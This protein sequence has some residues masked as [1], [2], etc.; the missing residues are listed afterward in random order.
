M[1]A[2]NGLSLELGKYQKH[3][4]IRLKEMQDQGFVKRLWNKDDS[5]WMKGN[6]KS[7]ISTLSM[8]WLNVTNKMINNLP[9]IKEF[10]ETI[11]LEGFTHIVLLGMGG[12]SLTPLVFQK[13][14]LSK[15]SNGQSSA[16]NIEFIVLDS[17]EPEMVRNVENKINIS[18]T[19]FIVASKSGNTAEVMAFYNY[20]FKQ[21]YAVKGERTGDNF[22]AITDEGSPLSELAIRQKF[23]KSFINFTDI[24]GRYSALSYF[25][26]LPAALMGVN[27]K[28]LLE[29]TLIMI[30]ACGS[31]VPA[32]QNPGVILGAA[33][34]ELATQGHDKLT[35]LLPSSLSSFGLWLEQLLAESTGKNH[36]GILPLNGDPLVEN[37][38]YGKDRLFFQLELSGKKNELQSRKLKE[39]VSLDHPLIGIQI[40]DELDLGME[41]FRWEIATATAGSI[42]G[43]NP[44]D[45][46]NV[47]ESKKCTNR[48]LKILEQ[49]GKLPD[50]KPTLKEN[51]VQYYYEPQKTDLSV[52]DLLFNPEG[53]KSLMETFLKLTKPGEYISIQA[54][55]PEETV[56]NKGISEI[57]Q[58]LQKSLQVAV[59]SEFGPRY[60]H[61]TGQYYKGGPNTGLFIQ[62]ICSTADD[63]QIPGCT[64]SFGLL[65]RA[66][67]IGD[68]EALI[69]NKRR[70]ILI[71]LEHDPVKGLNSFKQVIE[72]AYPFSNGISNKVKYMAPIPPAF[73]GRND[74]SLGHVGGRVR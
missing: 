13:T 28:E 52:S 63:I 19:L 48:L 7:D 45:Q 2:G 15:E 12:S 30:N 59:T 62:L 22:I 9:L 66:Q 25:G 29:R 40:N 34:A 71:D 17:T 74:Y 69:K 18:K 11:K 1:N 50:M 56:I 65:K 10:C 3:I 36:K 58:S 4:N 6:V 44:F 49:D 53:A 73:L 5:L 21:V 14:F 47:Q 38:I 35:Y 54:Y 72:E 20:F 51:S 68:R 32:S 70:V 55:L 46:P 8:G 23:R 39:L 67:A 57:Q 31:E 26:I 37:N 43:I 16:E 27:V 42:L 33:I 60:L 61:S 24:G 64:Y 41:F